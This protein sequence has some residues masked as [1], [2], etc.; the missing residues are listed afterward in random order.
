MLLNLVKIRR[1]FLPSLAS[2]GHAMFYPDRFS[3]VR[4][5]GVLVSGSFKLS[6]CKWLI[7]ISLKLY[8]KTK[9]VFHK[10]EENPVNNFSDRFCFPLGA[11]QITTHS[12]PVFSLRPRRG[13][14]RGYDSF[15]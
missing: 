6:P 3:C 12:D 15:F 9:G 8:F 10:A 5:N 14:E 2:R 7:N 13:S 4:L 11:H 1:C